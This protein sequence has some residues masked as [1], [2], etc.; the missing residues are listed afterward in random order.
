MDINNISILLGKD[1]SLL[2]HE[3]KTITKDTIHQAGPL[4][5]DEVFT[6]SNRNAQVQK[7]LSQLYKHGRLSNTGYLSIL[8][9]DQGIEHS[10][11]ASFAPNPI[12]F[13]PENIVN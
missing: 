11:A 9:V 7:S 3:C 8:P 6:E 5:I 4:F 12:Y 2:H 1:E 13:N 10:A